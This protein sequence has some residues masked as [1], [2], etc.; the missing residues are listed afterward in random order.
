MEKD[1]FSTSGKYFV[2]QKK[3]EFPYYFITTYFGS[4]RSAAG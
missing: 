1:K 2:E 3:W 4:D